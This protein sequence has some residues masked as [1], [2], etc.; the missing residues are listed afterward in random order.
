MKKEDLLYLSACWNSDPFLIETDDEVNEIWEEICENGYHEID[1]NDTEDYE[2]ACLQ[3][4]LD[5]KAG[6]PVYE[7]N[8]YSCKFGGLEE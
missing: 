6:Y 1:K 3:L 4:D 5:P 2:T 7:S 8:N